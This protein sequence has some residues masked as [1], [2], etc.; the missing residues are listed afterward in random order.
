MP[1]ALGAKLSTPPFRR[2]LCA[3]LNVSG[4]V[5]VGLWASAVSDG[6]LPIRLKSRLKS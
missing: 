1:G 4:R 5:G 3:L 6:R 2:M